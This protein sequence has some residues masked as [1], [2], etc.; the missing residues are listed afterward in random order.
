MIA[1]R[2]HGSEQAIRDRDSALNEQR[3]GISVVVCTYNGAAR[4]PQ[5]LAHLAAQ[6]NTGAVAWEVLVVDN[7]STDDTAE[8]ARRCWPA[9][10]PTPLRVVDE[11][12]IGLSSA[13]I[14]GFSEARY[15]I[16]SFIDDDNWVANDWISRVS[17]TMSADSK[18]GAFNG[19]SY[20]VCEIE[21]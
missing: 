12:R 16:V 19:L 8:V 21:P 11:P 14:R 10:A 7:A 4:L 3:L 5:T 6:E 2:T 20:P 15:E 1:Q 17:E 13:R 9:D 18:L